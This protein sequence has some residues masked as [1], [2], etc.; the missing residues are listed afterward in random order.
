LNLMGGG[1]RLIKSSAKVDFFIKYIA[2]N[3][4]LY[5]ASM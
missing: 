3:D 1:F 2:I 4:L 5:F